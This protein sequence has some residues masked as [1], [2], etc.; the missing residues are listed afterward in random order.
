M[1]GKLS[2][3]FSIEKTQEHI[4]KNTGEEGDENEKLVT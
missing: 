4:Q 2:L 3:A 1:N